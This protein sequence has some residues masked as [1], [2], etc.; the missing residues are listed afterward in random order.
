[1][2]K[3]RQVPA[4]HNFLNNNRSVLDAK[5]SDFFAPDGMEPKNPALWKSGVRYRLA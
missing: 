4:N 3:P 1:M 5:K 2:P